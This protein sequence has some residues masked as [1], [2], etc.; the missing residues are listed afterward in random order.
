MLWK[1]WKNIKFQK[2]WLFSSPFFLISFFLI[3]L[4]LI[5]AFIYAFIGPSFGHYIAYILNP[6]NSFIHII[7]DSIFVGIIST[8][9]CILIG[10]PVAILIYYVENKINQS[11]LLLIV[12]L[13]IWLNSLVRVAS[14]EILV[15]IFDAKNIYGT[16]F[17]YILGMVYLYL[18]LM[19][20]AI[21]NGLQNI[22]KTL[23]NAGLDLGKNWWYIFWKIILPLN[24]NGVITGII[25]VLISST[26]NVVV[27]SF[28]NNGSHPLIGNE[29]INFFTGNKNSFSIICA[30][31]LILGV[32]LFLLFIIWK[33][34]TYK[35]FIFNNKGK[36]N[37]IF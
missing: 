7:L 13:P 29:I 6:N 37:E 17:I 4:P 9:I 33:I 31:G 35:S 16:D 1:R 36:N 22:D 32:F 12:T 8:I 23:I 25:L 21:Y 5:I 18:P 10:Y 19:I 20:I 27:P 34:I 2:F 24:I 30:I 15:R 28:L 26:T 3:I 11:F 14:L